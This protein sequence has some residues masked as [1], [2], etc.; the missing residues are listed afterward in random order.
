M[1]AVALRT[2]PVETRAAV[3]PT[4]GADKFGDRPATASTWLLL[5]AGSVS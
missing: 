1:D 4:P 5:G 2:R 3:V